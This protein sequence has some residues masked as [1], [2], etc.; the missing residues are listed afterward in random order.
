MPLH[1]CAVRDAETQEPP[2]CTTSK[3]EATTAE[4]HHTNHN[5]LDVTRGQAATNYHLKVLARNIEDDPDNLTRFAVI[6]DAPAERTGDDKTSLMFEV[7]HR[8]GALA[9]AM[10]IFKRNRLNMTWIESFPLPR[11][12]GRYLFFV[13]FA[14]HQSDLRVRRAISALE[15]KAVRLEV[16]G[17]FA[18]M[19][20]IG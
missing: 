11:Q 16:L 9:D 3:S 19:Q 7:D 12:P 10:T 5:T 15:K 17:S 13:E 8:P 14:G 2:H 4:R 20:P 1:D 6:S 18:C